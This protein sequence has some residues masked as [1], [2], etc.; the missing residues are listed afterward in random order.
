MVCHV[1]FTLVAVRIIIKYGRCLSERKMQE[2]ST[3]NS[4]PKGK[5]YFPL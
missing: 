2:T 4:L 5:I 1:S 3:W